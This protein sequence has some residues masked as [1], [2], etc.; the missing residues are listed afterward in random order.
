MPSVSVTTPQARASVERG[1]ELPPV[2]DAVGD[3]DRLLGGVGPDLVDQR[4]MRICSPAPGASN[5][6]QTSAS[7]NVGAGR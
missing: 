1:H 5:A 2:A 4:E 6:A 3:Q 7:M